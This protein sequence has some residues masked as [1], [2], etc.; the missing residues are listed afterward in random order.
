MAVGGRERLKPGLAALLIVDPAGRR[1]PAREF[2]VEAFEHGSG[3]RHRWMASSGVVEV[4]EA[5]QSEIAVPNILPAISAVGA[6]ERKP[7]LI[8]EY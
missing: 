4:I 8:I 2:V 3:I 5:V 1:R 6:R 7:L